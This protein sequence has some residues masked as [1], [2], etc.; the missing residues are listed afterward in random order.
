LQNTSKPKNHLQWV[1]KQ[2]ELIN[3]FKAQPLIVVLRPEEKDYENGPEGN[4]FFLI[5]QLCLEGIIHVEIGWSSHPNWLNLIEEIIKKF[6]NTL[7]GAASITSLIALDSVIKVGLPYSMTPSWDESL[8]IHARESNQV[9]IPGVFSPTEI[10]QAISFGNQIVKLFPAS[11][12]G[13]N[14]LNRIQEPLKPIPFMIAAGGILANDIEEWLDAG[15]GAVAL[16][17]GLINNKKFDPSLRKWL[18]IQSGDIQK[19]NY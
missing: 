2:Q 4:L 7:F 13:K 1:Q 3:S 16:G 8:Q 9:L 12:L 5:E 11:T 15:F 18:K 17:R 6:P 10:Q 19:V 14:Y